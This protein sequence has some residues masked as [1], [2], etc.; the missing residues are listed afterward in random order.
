MSEE[1]DPFKIAQEQLDR[2]AEL[3]NLDKTAH[4]ILREPV[5]TLTVNIPCKTRNGTTTFTG[6]RV[7][8]NDARGPGKK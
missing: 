4:A 3:M 8:Y 6:F 1:L 7:Q 2:A 5:R